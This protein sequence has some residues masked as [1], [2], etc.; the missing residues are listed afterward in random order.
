MSPPFSVAR[1]RPSP[2]GPDARQTSFAKSAESQDT[3]QHT[4]AAEV[5]EELHCATP[6]THS[7]VKARESLLSWPVTPLSMFNFSRD[8]GVTVPLLDTAEICKNHRCRRDARCVVQVL[9]GF[10]RATVHAK[11]Y[12][13]LPFMELACR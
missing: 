7:R 9:T 12:R 10:G 13:R 11:T 2:G 8:T 1:P 5:W 3:Q 6:C 4:E